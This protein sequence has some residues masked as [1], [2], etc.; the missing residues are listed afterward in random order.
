MVRWKIGNRRKVHRWQPP[1]PWET[2]EVTDRTRRTVKEEEN[3]K[4]KEEI[5]SQRIAQ[6]ILDPVSWKLFMR[7]HLILSNLKTGTFYFLVSKLSLTWFNLKGNT[8]KPG[9]QSVRPLNL[10][11]TPYIIP[12]QLLRPFRQ[13]DT[14]SRL[15]TSSLSFLPTHPFQN[16]SRFYQSRSGFTQLGLSGQSPRD[17]VVGSI[18]QVR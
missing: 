3:S 11:N 9:S 10:S 8:I 6:T 18:R 12:S 16:T 1:Y 5:D 4:S 14:M 17:D 7:D 2:V 15:E 13:S